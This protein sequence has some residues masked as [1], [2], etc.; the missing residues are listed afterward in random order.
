MKF[1]RVMT[2]CSVIRLLIVSVAFIYFVQ[3]MN[4]SVSLISTLPFSFFSRSETIPFLFP[5]YSMEHL[6]FFLFFLLLLFSVRRSFCKPASRKRPATLLLSSLS[7]WTDSVE[8][9]S[10]KVRA[11]NEAINKSTALTGL[12]T[13]FVRDDVSIL[14]FF[15]CLHVR[16]VRPHLLSSSRG[17]L[18]PQAFRWLDC[19]R[20]NR[21]FS[22]FFV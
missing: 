8:L 11:S 2:K 20:L 22:R 12:S 13:L 3:N 10:S 5:V 15:S 14:E 9:P 19:H 1:I 17:L 7:I 4:P 16:K 21:V 18:L 6:S